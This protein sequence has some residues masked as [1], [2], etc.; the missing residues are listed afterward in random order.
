M[1]K[2]LSFRTQTDIREPSSTLSLSRERTA[3]EPTALP[4]PSSRRWPA[5]RSAVPCRRS[6]TCTMQNSTTSC[7]LL[8]HLAVQK[9]PVP[10]LNNCTLLPPCLGCSVSTPTTSAETHCMCPSASAWLHPWPS[11]R[12]AEGFWNSCT[13]PSP[14]LSLRRCRWRATSTTSSTR[15]HCHRSGVPWSSWAY[16]DLWCVRDPARLSAAPLWLPPAGGCLSC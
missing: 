10:P 1:P 12:P 5:S 2:G 11:P 16:T 7:T 8:P 6:T 14:R 3:P 9:T 4:S 13:R 15:S